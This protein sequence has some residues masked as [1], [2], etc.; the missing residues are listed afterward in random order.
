MSL[1]K[2][3]DLDLKKSINIESEKKYF[4]QLQFLVVVIRLMGGGILHISVLVT[5]ELPTKDCSVASNKLI[6]EEFRCGHKSVYK[7][8]HQ[9]L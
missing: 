4:A 5:N 7:N 6:S 2:L 9:I 8:H 1:Y 3:M